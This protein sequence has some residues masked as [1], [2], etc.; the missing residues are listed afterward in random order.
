MMIK[1]RAWKY[2]DNI[3]T[4]V[5][6]PGRYTYTVVKPE[7]M[8]KHAMEDLDPDFVKKVEKGDIIV[9]GRNFGCGSSRE[10]AVTALKYAGI[11]AIIAESFARIY[12]RNAINL[13]VPPVRLSSTKGIDD[14]DILEIYLKD[15]VVKNI[16]K[17]EEYRFTPFP[18][19]IV[20]IIQDGG[21]L[22]N[23]KKR[24][25]KNQK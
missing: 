4:D 2:G 12:Y 22:E 16:T 15:G 7:E 10:Q 20:R 21:L 3:N 8:A 6:F 9:A 13:G 1:G 19:F 23:L 17:G 18:D 25:K 14:G 11:S 24:L 5:L